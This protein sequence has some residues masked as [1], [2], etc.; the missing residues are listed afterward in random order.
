VFVLLL[1]CQWGKT[2]LMYAV[3]KGDVQSIRLLLDA[4]AN[5][6]DTDWVSADDTTSRNIS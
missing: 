6:F 1:I 4:G 2:A 5:P 3:S